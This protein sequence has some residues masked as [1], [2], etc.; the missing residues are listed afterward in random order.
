MN[1]A[2]LTIAPSSRERVLN[3]VLFQAGWFACVLGAARGEGMAGAAV[4]MGVALVYIMRAPQPLRAAALIALACTLGAL[5]DSAL[6]A[7]GWIGYDDADISGVMFIGAAPLWIVALWAL[8]A[9]TLN[10]SLGW[11]Q[12]RPAL[13]ALFGAIGGPL[14][15]WAGER[16]GAL[17]L[18]SPVAALVA[19]A[20]GWALLTPLLM[21]AARR[22]E[23][24][25]A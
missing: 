25:K 12:G 4:A 2:A 3:F 22:I 20:A 15:Y 18:E 8:F 19:L 24:G 6:A 1:E 5:W 13:A 9:T 17:R 7:A 11:M 16:M 10:S 14:S 23:G 21:F